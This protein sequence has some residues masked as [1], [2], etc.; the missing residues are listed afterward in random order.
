MTYF[1]FYFFLSFWSFVYMMTT[2]NRYYAIMQSHTRTLLT[3]AGICRGGL[4][5]SI[6][7]RNFVDLFVLVNFVT[8]L[9]RY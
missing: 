5:E 9:P 7:T 1:I 8:G 2:S 6:T 3:A 4:S